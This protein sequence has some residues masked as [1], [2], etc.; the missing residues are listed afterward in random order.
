[1][2]F[3]ELEENLIFW[4]KSSISQVFHYRKKPLLLSRLVKNTG[5][6]CPVFSRQDWVKD[7]QRPGKNLP[8]SNFYLIVIMFLGVNNRHTS[9]SKCTYFMAGEKTKYVNHEI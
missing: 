7:G 3:Y 1:M 2:P 6:K 5:K 8:P 4:E 9:E